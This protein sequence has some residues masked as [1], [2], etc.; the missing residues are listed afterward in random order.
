MHHLDFVSLF[1]VEMRHVCVVGD[2]VANAL[3][4]I[5]QLRPSPTASIVLKNGADLGDGSRYRSTSSK[6]L[7]ELGVRA[8]LD[9]TEYNS[10]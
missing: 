10:L 6:Q 9:I 3:S 1:A 2:S 4:R 5:R 7:P 8:N